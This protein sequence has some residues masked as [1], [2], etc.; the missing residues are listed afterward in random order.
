MTET[1]K[2]QQGT[3][4]KIARL[5]GLVLTAASLG[6]IVYKL[7]VTDW[8]GLHH[9]EVGRLVLASAAGAIAYC[10]L[11]LLLGVAWWI[12]LARI[13]GQNVN[14]RSVIG[15]YAVTQLYKYLPT[16]VLH[17]VGRHAALRHV[18]LSHAALVATAFVEAVSL[19]MAAVAV[20]LFFAARVLI[21][22]GAQHIDGE[23]MLLWLLLGMTL[24]IALGAAGYVFRQK[25]F[26]LA[27]SRLKAIACGFL[28]A[29]LMH[30][31]F[32]LGSGLILLRLAYVVTDVSAGE[33]ALLIAVAAISWLLGFIVPGAAA[34]IGVREAVIILVLSQSL[35]SAAAIALAGLYRIATLGG[36]VLLAGVG[37][38]IRPDTAGPKN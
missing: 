1:E 26:D 21:E 23:S 12:L 11:G 22:V 36:D 35:G 17:F 32:F 6:Y 9:L 7:S 27:P 33:H 29:N 4:S 19:S 30:I 38:L 10:G 14:A 8:S 18:G 34:G 20:S 25:Q 2:P 15:I 5:I 24:L 3:T 16:N 37:S 13:S 31:T 28:L